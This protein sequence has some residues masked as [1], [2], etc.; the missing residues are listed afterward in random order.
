MCTSAH[1]PGRA[2]GRDATLKR[3]DKGRS[4]RSVAVEAG[5]STKQ[6]WRTVLETVAL[7]ILLVIIGLRPLIFERYDSAPLSTTAV[8]D[9]VRDASPVRT[10]VIDGLI[11]LAGAMWLGAGIGRVRRYR[12]TGLEWG[13]VIIAV[14]GVLSCVFA[15]NKRLAINGALDWVTCGVLAILVSQVVRTN[16]DW[17]LA[18]CV[19]MAS[20]AAHAVECFDQVFVT[21][22]QTEQMYQENR[23]AFWAEQEV[24]LDTP[25][26]ELFERRMA[27]REASGFLAHSNIAGAYLIMCGLAGIGLVLATVGGGRLL[28]GAIAVLV[29]GACVLTNSRGA[30]GAGVVVVLSWFVLRW[31]RLGRTRAVMLVWLIGLVGVLGLVGYGVSRGTLPGRSLAFRWQYWTASAEMVVDHPLTGVGSGNFGRHYLQYKT[32]DSPEEVKNPHNLVVQAFADWGLIGGVGL[33]VMLVGASRV[34]GRGCVSDEAWVFDGD[35]RH[36][37]LGMVAGVVLFGSRVWLLDSDDANF[38]YVATAIPAMAWGLGFAG[39]TVATRRV[40]SDLLAAGVLAGV[41]AFLMQDMV[42]FASIVPGTLTTVMVSWGLYVAGERTKGETVERRGWILTSCCVAIGLVVVVFVVMP[43][44]QA[45][46]FARSAREARTGNSA[47]YMFEQS[48]AADGLD[49]SYAFE[50]AKVSRGV[51][52]RSDDADDWLER[53]DALIDEAISRDPVHLPLYREK[54]RGRLLAGQDGDVDALKAAVAAGEKCLALYPNDPESHVVLADCLAALGRETEDEVVLQRAIG[55]LEWALALD[56]ARPAWET[57]RRMSERVRGE[58][59]L[60]MAEL[61]EVVGRVDV[62]DDGDGGADDGSD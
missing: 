15:G 31:L 19:V 37:L 22:P 44:Q 1:L 4:S 51:A 10:A 46:L 8:L 27:A 62:A 3:G 35:Q 20:A 12:W 6:I 26:V 14:A 32:I 36:W 45:S 57:I 53:H 25:Q 59:E 11:W 48:M 60:R 2:V 41:V 33:I 24:S 50:G 42:N 23:E 13:L 5:D 54:A 56:D 49:S 58:I 16:A 34:V 55:E 43:Q 21:F 7:L 40:R 9:D 38:L 61:I 17:R 18:I 28:G 29:L 47:L 52:M 39:M 30:I